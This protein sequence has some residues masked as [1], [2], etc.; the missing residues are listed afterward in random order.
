MDTIIQVES[1]DGQFWTI[2]GQGKG[3]R[4]VWL[5]TSVSGFWYA[6]TASMWNQT[7]FQDGA[8]YGGY[9]VD[10]RTF[11]FEVE[12]LRTRSAPW[13]RNW[14]DWVRAFRPDKD[15]KIWYQTDT[16][17]RYSVVRL[18]KN[19]DMTPAI[20]PER[21]GHVT[22]KMELVAGDPWWYEKDVTWKYTTTTDTTTSGTE[23]VPG[24]VPVYNETPILAWPI[25]AFQGAAGIKWTIPD[26]SFGL[27]AMHDRPDG[28][29]ATRVIQMAP[30]IANEHVVVFTDP[31]SP[32]G[33]FISS[34]DT[35][36]YARMNGQRFMYPIPE[37]TGTKRKP[38]YLPLSVSGA[39][40]G[41][42]IQL[43]LKSA[44]PTPMGMWA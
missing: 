19:A 37:Y 31:M 21:T 36:Y 44:W 6:P 3:D 34:L 38:V 11:S 5:G 22:V 41:A 26:Y 42:V 13:E 28:A 8:D 10:K 23:N 35:S 12:I 40:I 33:Q 20:D 39:P 17:R 24:G 7:A 25:W 15:S 18:S 27:E 29:D 4:G 14:S 43:R 32:D 1:W 9:R 30:T 2:A 16:G